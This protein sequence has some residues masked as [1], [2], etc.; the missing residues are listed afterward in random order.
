MGKLKKPKWN[1]WRKSFIEHY[2]VGYFDGN[3]IRQSHYIPM[4][5]FETLSERELKDALRIEKEAC[6]NR[7]YERLK[8]KEDKKNEPNIG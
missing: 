1:K 6:L 3:G 5:W 7:Y 4:T 8:E 2:L